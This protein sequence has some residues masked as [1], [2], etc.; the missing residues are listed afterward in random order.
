[1]LECTCIHLRRRF[2][3]LSL[4]NRCLVLVVVMVMSQKPEYC[5]PCPHIKFPDSSIPPVPAKKAPEMKRPP[6]PQHLL[7]TSY[8]TSKSFI[9]IAFAHPIPLQQKKPDRTPLSPSL[10]P[11]LSVVLRCCSLYDT[12][13]GILSRISCKN[14][15]SEALPAIP[16]LQAQQCTRITQAIYLS[17]ASYCHTAAMILDVAGG[18]V[19]WMPR[20]GSCTRVPGWG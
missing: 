19:D 18:C 16:V 9:S 17:R 20:Q 15:R 1:M 5:T 11:S 3:M 8:C 4:A 13:H 7:N 2:P 6:P 10:L 14:I 12:H